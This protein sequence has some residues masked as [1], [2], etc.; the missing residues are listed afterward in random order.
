MLALSRLSTLVTYHLKMVE[1]NK[2]N[3]RMIG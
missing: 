1:N 2:V 3:S